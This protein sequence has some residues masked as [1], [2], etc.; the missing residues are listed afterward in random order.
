MNIQGQ[1]GAYRV[2]GLEEPTLGGY[3]GDVLAFHPLASAP[4]L[5][6]GFVSRRRDLQ[7]RKI[8]RVEDRTTLAKSKKTLSVIRAK[9]LRGKS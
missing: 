1:G 7:M 9:Q 8:R 5:E 4:K 3:G 6:G 2:E